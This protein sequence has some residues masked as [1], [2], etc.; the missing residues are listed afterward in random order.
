MKKRENTVGVRQQAVKKEA[1]SVHV[2]VVRRRRG[3]GK[4][5]LP[6]GSIDQHWT[7]SSR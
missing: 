5:H 4:K 7:F 3:F 6:I 2:C 1:S